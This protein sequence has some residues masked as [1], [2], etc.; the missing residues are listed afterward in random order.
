MKR[1][2]LLLAF[3]SNFCCIIR[4]FDQILGL[5]RTHCPMY[6]V[7]LNLPILHKF[8]KRS[9]S[10]VLSQL[11]K[12]THLRQKLTIFLT[13]I[14]SALCNMYTVCILH[15]RCDKL[16]KCY[17]DQITNLDNK[18]KINSKMQK[19][20]NMWMQFPLISLFLPF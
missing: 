17:M 12:N 14:Y 11:T 5:C 15:F 16:W 18:D 6:F 7:D 8:C 2:F 4:K 9:N 3:P 10:G 1:V 19:I 13:V 20:A